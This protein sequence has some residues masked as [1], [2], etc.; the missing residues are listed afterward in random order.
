MLIAEYNPK[1]SSLLFK[2]IRGE[3]LDSLL[4]HP[5]LWVFFFFFLPQGMWDLSS[6]TKDQTHTPTVLEVQSLTFAKSNK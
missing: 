3:T 2:Y 6:L 4:L 5:I 1:P